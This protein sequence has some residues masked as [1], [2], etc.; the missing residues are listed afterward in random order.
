VPIIYKM[1]VKNQIE[2]EHK[3]GKIETSSY[4]NDE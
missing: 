1:G 3:N 2:V 4:T